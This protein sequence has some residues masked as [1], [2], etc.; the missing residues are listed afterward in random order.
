MDEAIEE[1]REALRLNPGLAD[2]RFNLALAYKEKGL[3]VDA[4]REFKEYL[5]L[6]PKDSEVRKMLEGM[7]TEDGRL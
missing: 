7:I 5:R 1:Y 3:K 4:I 6:N 2:T